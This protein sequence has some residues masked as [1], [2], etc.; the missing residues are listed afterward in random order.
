M[1]KTSFFYTLLGF[2]QSH[3]GPLGDIEGFIQLIPGKYKSNIPLNIE[4]I[5]L[6]CDCIYGSIVNGVREPILF[7]FGVSSP[8]GY[9]LYKE[10]ETKLLNKISKSVLSHFQS[11]LEDDDHKPTDFNGETI[12][13]TCQLIK[14]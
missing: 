3:L 13:F 2:T 8:R 12:R 1:T 14:I 4:K 7:C 11:Y 10:S 9:K 6:K 5:H